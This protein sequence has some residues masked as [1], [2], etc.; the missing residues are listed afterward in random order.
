MKVLISILII[1]LALVIAKVGGLLA[2]S[3]L[4]VLAP[5]WL[6]ALFSVTVFVISLVKYAKRK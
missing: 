4:L 2:F 3:W 6:P 5:I 1:Q